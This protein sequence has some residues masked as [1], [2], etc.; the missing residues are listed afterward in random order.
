MAARPHA[1]EQA[2][3]ALDQMQT[4]VDTAA[5]RSRDHSP[6]RARDS[7]RPALSSIGLV[8]AAL[9]VL[10]AGGA[11]L[12]RAGGSPSSVDHPLANRARAVGGAPVLG[13]STSLRLNHHLVR[14]AATPRRP[15]RWGA[16]KDPRG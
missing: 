8:A 3:R 7:R 10:L 14:I 1:R 4:Y 5:P 2:T 13:P 15:R 9:A 11:M 12:S 6:R 16:A